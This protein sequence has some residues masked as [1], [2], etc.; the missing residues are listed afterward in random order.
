MKQQGRFTKEFEE[1]AVQPA[2]ERS[3]R[4]PA[5]WELGYRRCSLDRPEPGS[6]RCRPSDGSGERCHGGAEAAAPGER[7]PSP[8]AG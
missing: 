3:A 7:D 8:G 4:S 2:G 6:A 5:I 1:E